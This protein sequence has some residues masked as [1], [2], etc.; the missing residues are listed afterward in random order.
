VHDIL[1]VTV[2]MLKVT[3]EMLAAICWFACRDR[4]SL[5][6]CDTD[7]SVVAVY[8]SVSATFFC[9]FVLYV[10]VYVFVDLP[11]ETPTS[12]KNILLRVPI[13]KSFKKKSFF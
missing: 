6:A 1:N 4:P 13:N 12:R 3:V 5:R 11:F 10:C 9:V 2:E 8:V 7:C